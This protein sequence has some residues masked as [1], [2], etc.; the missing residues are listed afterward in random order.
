MYQ[1][2][3]ADSNLLVW[4]LIGL[5]IFVAVFAGVLAWVFFGLRD[6]GKLEEIAAL[7]LEDDDANDSRTEGRAR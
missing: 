6:S 1:E 3:Y 7:P 5:L 2:F 4:P